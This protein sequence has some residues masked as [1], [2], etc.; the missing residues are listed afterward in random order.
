MQDKPKKEKSDKDKSDKKDKSG[1]PIGGWQV[2]ALTL[3]AS[4]R[5]L[6]LS[7]LAPSMPRP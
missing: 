2:A 7:A 3:G 4:S 6:G 1:E 5:R